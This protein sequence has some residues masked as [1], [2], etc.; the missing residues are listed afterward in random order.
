MEQASEI[1]GINVAHMQEF[2]KMCGQDASKGDHNPTLVGHWIGGS[3]SRVE[4]KDK[5]LNVGGPGNF[6][7]MQLLLASLVGCDVDLIVVH[8]SLLGLKVESLSVEVTGH[9]NLQAYLG[10]PGKSGSGY[11]AVSYTVRLSVP[12]A[13]QEQV[14]YLRERCERS[15]PVADSLAR[16]IPV[17][18][19]FTATT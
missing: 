1:N 4:F 18:L 2:K 7:A 15:S 9:F 11:D 6:D 5:I 10:L 12:G 3:R 19:Q 14:A 13:T 8:A 17:Q 16:A